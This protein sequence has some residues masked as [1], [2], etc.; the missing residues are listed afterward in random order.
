MLKILPSILQAP[1]LDLKP[2]PDQLKYVF[3]GERDTLPVII[4]AKLGRGEEEKLIRV[5]RQYKE[6]MGWTITD[7]KGM[8]PSMCMHR[9]LMEENVKPC[10]QPQRRLN[11][12]MMEVVKKE[13]LK[14]LDPGMI[15]PISDSNWVSPI[16]VVPKKIGITVI[17]NPEG[18]IVPTR[19]QNG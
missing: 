1:N 9:I 7:I 2:L 6:A 15:Y 13:V 16:H 4:S 18:D 11:P 10:R 12:N 19:V 14:L 5:L 3:L 8:S 17:T